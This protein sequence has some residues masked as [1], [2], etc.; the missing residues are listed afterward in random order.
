MKCLEGEKEKYE[1]SDAM[2]AYDRGN[3]WSEGEFH[4]RKG[5][6]GP[7]LTGQY[8]LSTNTSSEEKEGRNNPG[9]VQKHKE[10]WNGWEQRMSDDE[11]ALAIK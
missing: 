10:L 7:F 9:A 11:I 2:P 1:G 6:P 8:L 5:D 4:C 3:G